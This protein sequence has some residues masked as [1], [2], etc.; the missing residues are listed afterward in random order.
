[1]PKPR[2]PRPANRPSRRHEIRQAALDLLSVQPPDEISVSDIAAH[3][4]MTPAAF[5][6]HYSSKDDIL[7][8]IVTEFAGAWSE[9]VSRALADLDAP[10]G[11]GAFTDR[12]LAW[13]GDNAAAARVYFVTSVGATSAGEALRRRTRTDLARRVSRRLIQIGLDA[14]RVRATLAGLALVTLLEVAAR[15]RLDDDAGYRTLGPDRFARV[16]AGLA[17]TLTA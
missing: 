15:A 10:G 9:E 11:I 7:G 16:V 2:T 5:Y 3:C 14:D 13:V 8:E 1:M 17:A 12:V 4:G 6:Y